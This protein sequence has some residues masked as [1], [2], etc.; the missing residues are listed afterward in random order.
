MKKSKLSVILSVVM[1]LAFLGF[2]AGM[3]ITVVQ[4]SIFNQQDFKGFPVGMIVSFSFFGLAFITT[5][6]LAVVNKKNLNSPK[7][8]NSNTYYV[9]GKATNNS[10]QFNVNPADSIHTVSC[11]FCRTENDPDSLYCK[12]CGSKLK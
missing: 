2:F 7:N 3:I 6:V 5:A 1:I 4:F 8:G 9:N 11:P 10:S 12:H